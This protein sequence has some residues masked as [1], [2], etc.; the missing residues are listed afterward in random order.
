MTRACWP[1][2]ER[3]TMKA[4][5]VHP[6]PLL[7]TNV[8]LRLEPLGLELVAEAARRARHA[9]RIIDLQVESHADYHRM[10]GEWQPDFLAFSCNYLANVP[11]LSIWPR[12]RSSFCRAPSSASAATALR[13][14]RPPSWSTAQARSIACSRARVSLALSAC[15]QRSKATAARSAKCP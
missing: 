1:R 11:R 8:F 7:Y 5:F 13:S 6:G 4:L 15:L 10:I 2:T 9:V 14:P 3:V 12:P